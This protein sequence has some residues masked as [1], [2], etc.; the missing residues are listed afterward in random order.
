MGQSVSEN[1]TNRKIFIMTL[2]IKVSNP[3]LPNYV[4]EVD[5]EDF[6]RIDVGIKGEMDSNHFLWKLW[7]LF[8]LQYA[9]SNGKGFAPWAYLPQRYIG[10][11]NQILVLGNIN[12]ALGNFHVAISYVTKG[13]IDRGHLQKRVDSIAQ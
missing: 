11:N 5:F 4:K 1:S 7:H 12:T 8:D 9:P 3:F 6:E 10:K 13:D 2:K